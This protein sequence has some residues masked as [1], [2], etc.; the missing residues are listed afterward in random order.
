MNC[1]TATK[2][3][4][5]W[6]DGELDF[7]RAAL[8]QHHLDACRDCERMLNQLQTV[9]VVLR[10]SRTSVAVPDGFTARVLGR[11]QAETQ[12]GSR[13]TH[14][15]FR[16]LAF[17][18]S[19]I[20]LLGMNALLLGRYQSGGNQA[21]QL[22]HPEPA[23][24]QTVESLEPSLLPG[25]LPSQAKGREAPAPHKPE[26]VAAEQ[27]PA[28]Q[29]SDG[30]SVDA[31][32]PKRQPSA[33]A[34]ARR[35]TAAQGLTPRPVAL[36]DQAAPVR[37]SQ[38]AAAAQPLMVA[39]LSPVIIP[40]PEVFIP[41]RRVTEG[42]LLKIAV[43]N[44]SRASQLLADAAGRH[45]LAPTVASVTLAADGRLIMLYRYEMPWFQ[46]NRFINEALHLGLVLDERHLTEDI[47]VEYERKLEQYRQLAIRVQG[48]EGAE[49][50]ML[51]GR[52]NALLTE[53]SRMHAAAGNAQAVTVWLES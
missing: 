44:L 23:G 38:P 19:F 25:T 8:L 30:L 31:S 28:E 1:K 9:L 52:K 3:F 47:S 32:P 29:A 2:L 27:A 45:G 48:A 53:L 34:S 4:S 40:D 21:A 20:F 33:V 16:K 18:A 39:A 7:N 42:S 15:L 14:S 41:K 26:G 37:M 5:A 13:Q 49:A 50:T 43:T 6:L 12:R 24:K 46:A 17:A 51:Q 22:P 11:L 36:S 10:E 35:V